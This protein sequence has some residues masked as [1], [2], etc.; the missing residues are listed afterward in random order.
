VTARDPRKPLF[1][2]GPA[3]RSPLAHPSDVRRLLISRNNAASIE[4]DFADPLGKIHSRTFTRKVDAERFLKQLDV[5]SVRGR[6]DPRN[7][8]T[9]LAEWAAEFML[10]C[11]RLSPTTQETY[12][13]DLDKYVLPRFGAYRLGGVPADQIENW[14]NDEIEAG[15][16]PSSRVGPRFR[17]HVLRW[18]DVNLSHWN[19]VTRSA[20]RLDL[21]FPV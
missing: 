16:A 15:L 12:R 20:R 1:R 5:D 10:L 13:R 18:W 2:A 19:T 6:I 9:P 7:A 14:L 4:P 17:S 21:V 11:R 8:D 3:P